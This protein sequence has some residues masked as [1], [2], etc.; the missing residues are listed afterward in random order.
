MIDTRPWRHLTLVAPVAGGH[1]NEVWEGGIGA[2]RVAVRRSRRSGG[3]L[4]WELD[5]IEHLAAEGFRVPVVVPTD[6]GRRSAG[7]VVVQRWLDGPPPA[8]PADWH[9]VGREL[10]RLHDATRGYR[11][12]PGCCT[13][14]ELSDVRR[15]VDADLDAVPFDVEKRVTAVFA[16]V[17]D[18]PVAV[19]HGDTHAGNL[20]MADDGAVGLLDWDESRL[21]VTWHD[22]SSLPGV[23]LLPVEARER[24]ERLSHAWEAVNAW[25]TEPHYARRR[26]A[27]LDGGGRGR[28]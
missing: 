8:S 21:D 3:S 20:R 27:H 10:Q 1:R 9:R 4:A 22:L 28:P 17:A 11:Q 23:D 26:L 2:T 6:D 24:A 5:L 16:A 19:V 25:T 15:S 7:D 18:A 12:R 13:V 14:G